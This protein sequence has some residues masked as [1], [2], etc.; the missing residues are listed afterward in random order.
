MQQFP[1]RQA[2]QLLPDQYL[3]F[4]SHNLDEARDTISDAYDSHQLEPI[5]SQQ[6]VD[7]SLHVA[8]LNS[9]S[10]SLV[11]YASDVVATVGEGSGIYVLMPLMGQL[12]VNSE[13]R[14]ILC[15]PGRAVI[16]NAGVGFQKVMRNGYKQLVVKFDPDALLQHLGDLK[17]IVPT[18][19]IHFDSA[20]DINSSQGA[21]WWRTVNYVME[22][23]RNADLNTPQQLI[24][25]PLERLLI[26]NILRCQPHNYSEALAAP[27]NYQLA[28]W[29]VK[30]AEDY[31]QEYF[32]EA[33][34]LEELAKATGVSSRSLQYGFKKAHGITPM[35][36]LKDV[37]LERVRNELLR[38]DTDSSV[39][40][41]AMACGFKQLG[42][43]ASQYKEKYGETPSE[44]LRRAVADKSF[45]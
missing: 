15:E 44:T 31:L 1:S 38:G 42:W 26:Q 19:P 13:G 14:Q 34:T 23:L 40:P 2:Q 36:Y 6:S 16:Q 10:F 29:Y 8:S 37:R 7:V 17:G 28:P 43:F 9:V 32:G 21:S 30:R 4:R 12:K 24:N 11:H 18:A 25:E 41:V 3:W 39:T 27:K 20:M 22:E 35:Q 5:G 33:V 45:Q